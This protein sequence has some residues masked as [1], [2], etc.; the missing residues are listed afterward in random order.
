VF[1]AESLRDWRGHKVI[2]ADGAKIGTLEAVYVD[3]ATDEPAFAAVKVS[4]LR[5]RRLV[6]VPLAGATVA[7][8]HLRVQI[9]KDQAKTA[10]S[11]GTDG[12]LRAESEPE[13]FAHY[14]LPYPNDTP[15]VGRRAPRS[16]KKNGKMRGRLV[17]V[18]L[19]WVAGGVI[20]VV[21]KGL[22]WLF[23]I[24]C[25]AFAVTIVTGLLRGT[26]RNRVTR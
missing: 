20:G 22:F 2:D 17:V 7:P 9:S 4:A 8:D 26:R 13:L 21:V 16:P 15:G 24:A 6:F 1:P 12:E 5:G 18:V 11:I 23:I 10:P 14:E 25:V 3:T 19:G